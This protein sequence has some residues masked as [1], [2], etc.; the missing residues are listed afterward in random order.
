MELLDAR[1]QAFLVVAR[2][3]AVHRATGQLGISQTGI[4][5]R[6]KS[7]E[8]DLKVTL[9]S[10]SRTGMRLTSEGEALLQY[11][12]GAEE[13][14]GMVLSKLHGKL[15][16]AETH[17]TIAGPTS[18][19]S[20]RLPGICASVMKD[21]PGLYV[22][23]LTEDKI[24]RVDLVKTNAAQLAIVPPSQV[25][26]EMDSK[27]LKSDQYLLIGSHKW[28]S[29]KIEDI[30][31]SEKIIDFYESDDTTL[32]YLRK[33]KLSG[34]IKRARLFV[35]DNA[36]LIRLLT[37]GLGL[38]TLTAEIAEPLLASGK[39]IALNRGKIMED[40]LALVWYP[41]PQMP[42]YFQAIIR[43]LK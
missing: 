23:V 43:S 12:N 37:D 21:W 22:H 42:P 2:T 38:G 28:K 26:L 33:F 32:S 34:H 13:L 24:N 31:E 40:P 29:R 25:P 9:F 14:E 35:N 10:R 4:T 20:T 36:T 5:Q 18:A 16:H 30:L 11:C 27:K 19:V 15:T 3:G 8:Q 17:I 39:V 41:R 7:L 1:L 6:V